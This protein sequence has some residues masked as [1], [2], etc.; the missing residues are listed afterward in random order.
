MRQILVLFLSA[1]IILQVTIITVAG[2]PKALPLRTG[3]TAP[4]DGILVPPGRIQEL[5]GAE[6]E[7][8]EFKVKYET[9]ERLREIERGEY[10]KALQSKWYHEPRFNQAVGFILGIAVFGGAV[11]G[12]GQLDQ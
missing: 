6:I 10:K 7:R 2:E 8:D 5:L 1:C 11:W 3:E 9:S 12:A 4:F